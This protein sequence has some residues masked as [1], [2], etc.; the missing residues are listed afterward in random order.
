MDLSKI[1]KKWPLIASRLDLRKNLS[2]L[3]YTQGKAFIS[4]W[5]MDSAKDANLKFRVPSKMQKQIK[6]R[7]NLI[8]TIKKL[9]E[10]SVWKSNL[11]CLERIWTQELPEWWKMKR[12]ERHSLSWWKNYAPWTNHQNIVLT[13]EVNQKRSPNIAKRTE[14]WRRGILWIS[15]LQFTKMEITWWMKNHQVLLEQRQ[16]TISTIKL[17]L[18]LRSKTL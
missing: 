14:S 16:M 9:W 7:K 3:A 15:W 13:L 12:K 5:C 17:S 18:R 8:M 2:T 1:L 10:C 4:R 11:S 6:L